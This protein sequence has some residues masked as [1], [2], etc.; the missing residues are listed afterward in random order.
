MTR[1]GTVLSLPDVALAELAGA[2]LDLVWIDLEHGALT[3]RDAQALAIGLQGTGCAAHVRLP[4]WDSDLLP[5][6]LDAGVDGIVVPGAEEPAHVAAVA[7]RLRY[8]PAG[9]RGFGPRRAG[10][11]GRADGFWASADARVE[12]TVQV[13][14]PAGVEA[15]AG[16]AAVPGVDTV[17]VGCGDLS[18]ALDVPQDFHAA[19]LR[20]AVRGVAV[21]ATA[22][23]AGFGVAG[24]GDPAELVALAGRDAD[25]VVFSTDMRLYARAVD[26]AAD[27][28]RGADVAA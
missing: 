25:L 7:A 10:A 5:A 8:P 11:Y 16:I 21:A 15:A 17:V 22:A 3:V 28:L 27:A 20:A 19:P 2:P 18:L 4:R 14:T 12:L 13:E 26:A 24:G 1:I 23:G 9:S 6:L